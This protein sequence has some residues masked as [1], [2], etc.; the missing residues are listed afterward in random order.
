MALPH[1]QYNDDSLGDACDK[2]PQRTNQDQADT[3]GDNI[4]DVCDSVGTMIVRSICGSGVCG[5]GTAAMLPVIL[6]GLGLMKFGVARTR[7]GRR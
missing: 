1:K 2:C 5:T 4:G 6:L 3:D 7:R